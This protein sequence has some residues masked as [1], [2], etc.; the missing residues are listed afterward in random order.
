M[1]ELFTKPAMNIALWLSICFVPP[2]YAE[3]A[4][5]QC[6]VDY[7][8]MAAW[9][10]E[11]DLANSEHEVFVDDLGSVL[12]EVVKPLADKGV[13]EDKKEILTL[14]ELPEKIQLLLS[15]M[16]DGE[17][18]TAVLRE[19]EWGRSVLAVKWVGQHGKQEIKMLDDGTLLYLELP[20]GQSV[21]EAVRSMMAPNSEIEALRLFLSPPVLDL[22]RE[23]ATRLNE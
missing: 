3:S 6:E 22:L 9:E 4:V 14:A 15:C 8:G 23:R 7:G 21:P 11:E 1:K 18:P 17:S 20:A 12:F 19:K 13:E 2:I 5:R 10:I 16:L